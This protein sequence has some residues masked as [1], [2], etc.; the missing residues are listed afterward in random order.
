MFVK[1][2]ILVKVCMEHVHT[3]VSTGTTDIQWKLHTYCG[4]ILPCFYFMLFSM[5]QEYRKLKLEIDQLRQLV[6]NKH[7]NFKYIYLNKILHYN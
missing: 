2:K 5:F 4:I 6:D 7:G 1:D 3:S